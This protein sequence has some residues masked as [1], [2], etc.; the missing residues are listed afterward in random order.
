MHRREM[1]LKTGAAAL[2]LSAFPLRWVAAK[3]QQIPKILYFNRSSAWTHP[4]A[5]RQGKPLAHSEKVL[6]E[7]GE[8]HGFEVDCRQD[9]AVLDGDL[10]KYDL[11]SFY[12]NGMPFSVQ[13]MHKVLD[14][15]SSGKP[16][17]GFHAATDTLARPAINPFLA[18]LGGSFVS[19][20]AQ[21]KGRLRVAS[22]KFP[23]MQGLGSGFELYEEWY[24]Q[25]NFAKDMHVILMQETKGLQ[26][27]MYQR[28][29]YPSTWARMHG[30]GRVFYTSLGHREDVW[31]NPI[32]QQIILGGLSWALGQVNADITTNF[33]N[34]MS[35]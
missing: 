10:G 7:L 14:A 8:K 12:T 17:V 19:H 1:L 27:A 3:D 24:A 20:G 5:D 28:P 2:G 32:F 4:V 23:G 33:D 31:T 11:L 15:V 9:A 30:K 6:T 21:Q 16:C 26:G 35:S 13:Q 22:P 18:M 34:L 25:D 29:P